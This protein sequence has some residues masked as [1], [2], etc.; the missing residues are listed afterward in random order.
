MFALRPYQTAWYRPFFSLER[1]L[2]EAQVRRLVKLGE[3][4]P[5]EEATVARASG[6]VV[7]PE[8]RKARLAW[9]HPEPSTQR[10]FELL[11]QLVEEVNEAAYGF[12]LIGFAEPL[13]YTV[14]EAPSV[15][16][17]WHIDM[18]DTP[19][20]IQRKLSITIQLSGPR[21]Y[22]GGDLELRDGTIALT[23]P[24]A[25]GAVVAFPSWQPHRVTPVT[26]GTRRSLVAWVGGPRFR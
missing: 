4:Q 7:D 22:A 18:I 5:R 14:Y 2:T 17:D 6:T 20:S 19:D 9:V 26:R 16:Y 12:D 10:C 23:A 25:R 24:R 3:A 11:R 13:Q 8:F 1:R 15:G 21:E